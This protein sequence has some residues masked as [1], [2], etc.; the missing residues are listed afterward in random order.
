MSMSMLNETLIL[1][2]SFS[3]CRVM[4]WLWCWNLIFITCSKGSRCRYFNWLLNHFIQLTCGTSFCKT[5]RSL[6]MFK[7]NELVWSPT[8]EIENDN[9]PQIIILLLSIQSNSHVVMLLK[10]ATKSF[11]RPL[12][13]LLNTSFNLTNTYEATFLLKKELS[14]NSALFD[15]L[16]D[17]KIDVGYFMYGSL[18]NPDHMLW[19]KS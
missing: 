7:K 17:I 8:F 18:L 11:Q 5:E 12:Y 6:M 10:C 14:W 16:L 9:S 13:S 3:S 15:I 19:L 1:S 4:K 2:Q